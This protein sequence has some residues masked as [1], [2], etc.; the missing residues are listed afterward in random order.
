MEERGC[1]S[2]ERSPQTVRKLVTLVWQ[3]ADA[4]GETGVGVVPFDDPWESSCSVSIRR[5]AS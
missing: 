3:G 5:S 2:R 4:V 1:T